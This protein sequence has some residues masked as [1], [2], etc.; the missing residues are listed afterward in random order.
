MSEQLFQL[1]FQFLD[2]EPRAAARLLEAGDTANVIPFLSNTPAPVVARILRQMQTDTAAILLNTANAE[3]AQAWMQYLGTRE[4]SLIL[5]RL[6]TAQQQ[7]LLN[8]LTLK[9]KAACQLLLSF[10][11]DMVGA[12]VETDVIVFPQDLSVEESLKR[13][14]QRQFKE[15]HQLWVVDNNHQLVGELSLMDLIQSHGDLSLGELQHPCND[16][17][18]GRSLTR[19]ALN[20]PA[21]LKRDFLPVIN[22]QHELIGV[23]WFSQLKRSLSHPE[24]KQQALSDIQHSA[25]DIVHAHGD[26]MRALMDVLFKTCN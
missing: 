19:Y 12:I 5:R 10:R 7:D 20:H 21:W 24:P 17:L 22:R 25:L 2:Q 8:S 3:T 18:N 15:G 16:T 11:D 13:I 26:S 23:L 14:R 6:D 4:L 1:A 9:K